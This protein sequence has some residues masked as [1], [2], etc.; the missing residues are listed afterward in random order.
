MVKPTTDR[1]SQA[2]R[3]DQ[4]QRERSGEE[5]AAPTQVDLHRDEQHAF[6][7]TA[8]SDIL[9]TSGAARGAIYHHFPGGKEELA[10]AAVEQ[11]SR[12]I[13][14]HIGAAADAGGAPSAALRAYIDDVIA[15]LI[16]GDYSE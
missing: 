4:R 13:V 11:A 7:G 8:F 10:V 6:E 9:R 2:G 15:Q 12:R 16:A 5:R 1:D 3:D 14:D